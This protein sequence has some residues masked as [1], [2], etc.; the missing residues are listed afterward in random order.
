MPSG[1]D[2]V[3]GENLSLLLFER[4]GEVGE[5]LEDLFEVG[6]LLGIRLPAVSHELRSGFGDRGR[7][8]QA[9][10]LDGDLESQPD[11]V[12]FSLIG[13]LSSEQLFW[14]GLGS[15]EG[16]G[17]ELTGREGRGS[18]EKRKSSPPRAGPRS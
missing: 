4:A 17:G 1:D 8:G 5:S 13:L 14:L 11:Q 15:C 2:V 10:A 16:G 7:N 6:S 3:V 9:E 12:L 18:D